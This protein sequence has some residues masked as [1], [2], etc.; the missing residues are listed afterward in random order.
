[1]GI[2]F[3]AGVITVLL[4]VGDPTVAII[5]NYYQKGLEWDS[6]KRN[7]DRFD[8]LGWQAV[9]TVDPVN[10]SVEQ[11]TVSL[12]V[13]SATGVPVQD[14][15][16]SARVFHHARGRQ[17]YQLKFVQRQPGHYHGSTELLPAGLWQVDL[18][19]EG[20]HGDAEKRMTVMVLNDRPAI[21]DTSSDI[22][23]SARLILGSYGVQKSFGTDQS[24]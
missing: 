17:I 4:A 21:S 6:R 2:Q 23:T 24:K 13:I 15:R 11:R 5:P 22:S 8:Q 9:V 19:L 12:S 14:L 10:H 7:L 18:L 20:D 3:V 1:L 16:V